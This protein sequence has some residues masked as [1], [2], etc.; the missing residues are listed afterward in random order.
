ME[1][2]NNTNGEGLDKANSVVDS[3]NAA[4][5]AIKAENDR[6]ERLLERQEALR[7]TEILG[8]NTDASEKVEKPREETPQEYVAKLE[9][10]E[11]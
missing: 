11:L 8:G 10:G 5:G 3:A 4:A 6:F 1:E 9:R 7:A 2:E